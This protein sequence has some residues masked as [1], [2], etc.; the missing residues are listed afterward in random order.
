DDVGS[1]GL[2]P[3]AQAA[4]ARWVGR[5][6]GLVVTGG[7][8]LFGDPG[9]VGGPLERVLPVTLQSQAPEPKEREPS[10]LSIL[11]DRSHS[12]GFAEPGVQAGDKMEYAKRAALAVMGQL[13][14]SDL[15]G[16]IAFDSEPYEL[17]ALRP[18]G[19]SRE[20]LTASIRALRYGGGTDF[21][22]ALE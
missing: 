1:A 13:S 9:L 14:P 19:E 18:V 12:M 8:H 2:E 6:G 11:V 20:A 17:G 4:L 22:R 7:A 10:A 21:K 16:A 5:G 3:S 15:V